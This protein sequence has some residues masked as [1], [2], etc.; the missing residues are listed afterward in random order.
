[1]AAVRRRVLKPRPCVLGTPGATTFSTKRV[2]L[3]SETGE[4]AEPERDS[5]SRATPRTQIRSVLDFDSVSGA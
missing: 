4:G 5:S 3:G 1:M 2:P